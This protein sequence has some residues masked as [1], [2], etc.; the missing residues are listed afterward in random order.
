MYL[1]RSISVISKL[2]EFKQFDKLSLL[3]H[4][5]K[6]LN[7]SNK[8]QVTVVSFSNMATDHENVFSGKIDRFQGIT[9]IS[10]KEECTDNDFKYKLE[11]IIFFCYNF[12][13]TSNKFHR[14]FKLLENQW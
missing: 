8:L 14:I 2:I 4:S 5:N 6:V 13:I 3:I 11:G 10:D 1:F 12:Q 7:I 9:V